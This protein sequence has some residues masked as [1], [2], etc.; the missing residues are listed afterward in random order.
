MC[1]HVNGTKYYIPLYKINYVVSSVAFKEE[2]YA[3]LY[4]SFHVMFNYFI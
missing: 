2:K 3:I 1:V 4:K